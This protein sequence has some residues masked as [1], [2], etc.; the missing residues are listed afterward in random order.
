MDNNCSNNKTG[1]RKKN[2]ENLRE[3]KSDVGTGRNNNKRGDMDGNYDNN[4]ESMEGN[5]KIGVKVK[6]K[7]GNPKKLKWESVLGKMRETNII[8][9]EK[10]IVTIV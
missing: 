1:R 2:D 5:D 10:V 7:G 9:W 4:D 8:V 6:K 3:K